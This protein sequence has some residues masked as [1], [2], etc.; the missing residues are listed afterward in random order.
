[1][2]IVAVVGSAVDSGCVVDT[3]V[4]IVGRTAVVVS[5]IY[6]RDAGDKLTQHCTGTVA[7]H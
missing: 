7:G 2:D 5:Y 1:M 6:F 3:A 4:V